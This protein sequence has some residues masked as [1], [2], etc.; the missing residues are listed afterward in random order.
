MASGLN[1]RMGEQ[2][3]NDPAR[4]VGRPALAQGL[5][6]RLHYTDKRSA[7]DIFNMP[8]QEWASINK[9]G[10][11]SRQDVANYLRAYEHYQ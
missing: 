10:S 3:Q 9:G 7:E 2:K 8:E 4:G 11:V 5:A 6:S 1:G